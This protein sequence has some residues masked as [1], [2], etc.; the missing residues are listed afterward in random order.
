MSNPDPFAWQPS[1]NETIHLNPRNPWNLP[2]GRYWLQDQGRHTWRIYGPGTDRC[3]R[4]VSIQLKTAEQA[5]IL[6]PIGPDELAR[7]RQ[8]VQLRAAAP[9]RMVRH[10]QHDASDLALFRHA[11]EPG[12]GL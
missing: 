10:R 5:G 8:T 1:D 11:A 4:A 6:T 7:E 3:A 12:L 2:A 9:L